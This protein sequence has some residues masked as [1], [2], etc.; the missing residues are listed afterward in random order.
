MSRL[1]AVQ[2]RAVAELVR[3][4]PV[5]DDLGARFEAA[6]KELH[7]VG[8]SVRDALLGRLAGDL[9]FATDARPPDV[10][11][12]L[13]GWAD[14]TWTTGIEFGTV[15]AARGP[16]RCEITTFRTE[17]YRS[18]SRKP[19]VRY[20]ETLAEDLARRD[21][22]IN[23]M[24]YSL[25]GHV[26]CDPH[27][28]LRDL[29]ERVL[30]T[31]QSPRASFED[32]PLRMLRAMRFVAQLGFAVD[33]EVVAAV[34][35]MAGRL[36]IVSAERVRDEFSKLLT[37]PAPVAALELL[38]D[39]GLAEQFLPEIPRLRLEIDP[40]PAHRH[41]DVY[42][43]TLAVLERAVSLE[44]GGADLILRMAALLHDI[45]KPRTRA[46]GPAGVSFHHHEIVGAQLASARL[47]SLRY[48]G[49]FVDDVARLVE[50]HLRFH[51]YGE[52]GWTDSAVRRYVRD[53]G[54]LLDR[55]HVLVR[56]D[57]TTRNKRK[58]DA[59]ARA[60]NDLEARIERLAEQE[61]LAA[62]RP[63]LDGRQVMRLLGLPPGPAVGRALAHL[64]ELRLDRGP[65][66]P[67]EAEAEL[68]RWATEHGIAPSD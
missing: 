68:R 33:P 35:E 19:D 27:G 31:P 2:E 63:D 9:D 5:A 54:P 56:S 46:Y 38:V 32:D 61:E 48:P 36:A 23:A 39:T 52:G 45:G 8:G 21:F 1:T 17:S 34:R 4:S 10:E 42:R 57:C 14:A 43:H 67:V 12:L 47:K 24:A 11:R 18:A 16:W 15:G 53:A 7:L 20:G 51:G 44:S 3:V 60:Y 25:P 6:G 28:G 13:S 22:T 66:S 50:L 49:P 58:A 29:A 59:L 37:A 62:V 65:L 26:F 41:K 40:D 55:L 64:L 30:R